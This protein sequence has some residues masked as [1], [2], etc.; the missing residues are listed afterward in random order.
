MQ[1]NPA[2]DV[3]NRDE[4]H[5]FR[6]NSTNKSLIDKLFLPK[7]KRILLVFYST[8]RKT[9]QLYLKL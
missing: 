4:K 5:T 2:I 7:K 3:S 1:C 9:F 8:F 6:L